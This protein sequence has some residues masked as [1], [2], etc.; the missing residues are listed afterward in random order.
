[1]TKQIPFAH[2]HLHSEHSPLD[3]ACRMDRLMGR[4]KELGMSHVGL[5]DHGTMSGLLK[6]QNAADKAGVKPILGLEAYFTEDR[7]VKDPSNRYYHLTLLA[8]T[9]EGYENLCKLSAFS[10]QEES[11]YY[12]PRMDYDLLKTYGK[13]IIVLTGCM[14]GRT[15]QRILAKDYT[16]AHEEVKN[17]MECVGDEN[18][19]VEIQ[20]VGV[21]SGGETQQDWNRHL[22]KIAKDLG[23]PLVGTGD[24]HYLNE[25]D[26]NPHDAMLCVQMKTTVDNPSRMSLLPNKYYLR[27][28]Q[29]MMDSLGEF[30]ESLQNTIEVAERCNARIEVDRTFELLPSFPLPVEFNSPEEP[31]PAKPEKRQDISDKDWENEW[32][33]FLYLRKQVEKGIQKR[34]GADYSEEVKERME[35]ELSTILSMGVTNYFLIIW[36]LMRESHQRGVP[37]GPGR[38]SGAGSIVLYALDV[39]QLDPLEHGLLFERFLNPDRISMPDVDL[40][41]SPERRKEMMDYMRERY[42]EDYVSQIIT[43]GRIG[44][45]AGIRRGAQAMG[46]EYLPLADKLAKAIPTKGTVAAPLHKAVEESPEFRQALNAS[47]D[48]KRIFGYAEWMEGMIQNEGVHAAAL[49]VSPLKLNGVVPIQKA[50]DGNMVSAFDMKDAEKVGL[51]KLDFLG[52]RNL[53]VIAECERLIEKHRGEKVNA[54]QVPIDDKKTFQMLG[55]GNSIGVFQFECL[56]ADTIINGESR[57]TIE[58]MYH[59]PPKKLLSIDLGEGK[60]KQNKVLK[61]V[62]SGKKQ[63]YRLTT[64]SGYTLRASADHKI[65]TSSGWKKMI[66]LSEQDY[67]VVDREDASRIGI[68]ANCFKQIKSRGGK[69]S[70]C[71]KFVKKY[72]NEKIQTISVHAIAEFEL[73]NHNLAHWERPTLPDNFEFEKINSLKEDKI[74]MTYDICMEAPLNNYIA[75]GIVVHNSGG[76]SDSLKS[77]GADQFSDLVAIVALYRPGP[78]AN[79]P[80]Y[81]KRKKGIEPIKYGDPR[82]EPI[83]G[84]TQ[85]II[86]YQEQSMLVSRE[87]A[88]FTP[89]EAD[90]LRKAIGKKNHELMAQLKPKFIEGCKKNHVPKEVAEELWASNEASAEY[91]FNKSHAAAYALVSYV[92]AYL[93]ANYP[94]EYMAALLSSVMSSKDKVPFYLYETKKMG[95]NVL[96]PDVNASFSRFEPAGEMAVRFGLTAIKGVGEL[97]VNEISAEREQ[98][99]HYKS[100]FDFVKRV[101]GVNRREVDALIKAGAFDST[102]YTRKGLL[103][104]SEQALKQAKSIKKKEET[105][106]SS[107]FDVMNAEDAFS[108]MQMVDEPTVSNQ[109]WDEMEKFSYEREVAGIYVSGHPLEHAQSAWERVRH[110]GIGQLGEE[111]IGRTLTIAGIITGKRVIFTKRDNKKMLIITLEDLTGAREIVVFPKTLESQDVER[112]LNEGSLVAMRVSVQEDDRSFGKDA[113]EEDSEKAIRMSMVTAFPFEPDAIDVPEFFSI[114]LK[115]EQLGMLSQIKEVFAEFPGTRPVKIIIIKDNKVLKEGILSKVSVEPS[116]KLIQKLSRLLS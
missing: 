40:D 30:P 110:A 17:M 90:T 41:F 45:K 82:L 54:W 74:E 50:K 104:V 49:I 7:K 108:A 100:L 63:L 15:M 55:S 102:G 9:T 72:A 83:L 42:G 48:A 107:L 31:V 14:A 16:G 13:G 101:D 113:E 25:E 103:E 57:T 77:I 106:Q 99:G 23:R 29:E 62:Q 36:D 65:L 75:N 28:P 91:S 61:I 88:G 21:K 73:E 70:A 78:M 71:R 19:Y 26:A 27:S 109:E 67:I 3:G 39:T 93:K 4:V 111:H 114:T 24:V 79:I 51:L 22:A 35:F 92:T 87:L 95:I 97:I 47:E 69:C 64:P 18:V 59:N 1:M 105:G 98:N 11:W 81:A 5:T 43:F 56:A 80:V 58:Q 84:E 32:A 6:F 8:E 96:P 52:L 34:Y 116:E 76:M 2:L 94:E 66:E 68:C 115:K 46:K 86:T 112:I 20:N 53:D 10:N 44:S 85:G 37:T 33:A 38:G 60:K 12:K 89:G